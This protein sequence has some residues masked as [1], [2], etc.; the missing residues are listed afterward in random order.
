MERLLTVLHSPLEAPS[1]DQPWSPER[2]CKVGLHRDVPPRA[3]V[4]PLLALPC[5]HHH[6]PTAPSLAR[7]SEQVSRAGQTSP[8]AGANVNGHQRS[9]RR[10]GCACPKTPPMAPHEETLQEPGP[11]MKESGL[12]PRLREHADHGSLPPACT[13]NPQDLSGHI[14]QGQ[15]QQSV[16]AL[17][18][19]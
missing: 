11:G 18:R 7:L 10:W 12:S 5:T 16:G 17:M 9:L 4:L 1:I 19:Q 14:I 2:R 8:A 6:C 3:P 15:R 13:P